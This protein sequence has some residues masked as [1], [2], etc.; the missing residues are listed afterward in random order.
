MPQQQFKEKQGFSQPFDQAVR[1]NAILFTI[2]QL[3]TRMPTIYFVLSKES[4]LASFRVAIHRFF[5]A[6]TM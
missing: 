3:H 6:F 5:L 2:L 1:L 4:S